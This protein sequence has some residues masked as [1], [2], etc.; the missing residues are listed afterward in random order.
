MKKLPSE[1][2]NPLVENQASITPL[3]VLD[4]EECYAA[5]Q[6]H[7]ARFDGVFFVA[8]STT[9]IYCRPICRV[10]IPKI[11]RCTFY[12][13]AASAEQ[14][15]YRPCLR[16]R[17]ELAP[18]NAQMDAV[19]R[20]AQLA[21]LRIK[22]GALSDI[23]VEGLAEEFGISDRQL[24]RAIDIEYG[25]SPINLAQTY[26]LL[27]AK[28]LLTDT[29]LNMT[30]IA[31]ASGF[32]SV[33]RFN[34][35]FKTKY[36]LNPSEL[37]KTNNRKKLAKKQS[38]KNQ[39]I[40]NTSQANEEGI[41]LRLGYRPP[42]AWHTLIH[43]LCS[44]GHS[45]V[46]C[47]KKN[48]HGEVVYCKTV[49]ISVPQDN[50]KI[51]TLTTTGWISASQDEK[52]HQIIVRISNSLSPHLV[53]LQ[54][55]LR[56]LFDLDAN[57]AV[58]ENHL[59]RDKTLKKIIKETPGIRI[60]GTLDGFELALRAVLGQ[61]ISV[62][63]ATTVFGRFVD[64]FGDDVETPIEGL[65]KTSPNPIT[66]AQA[67]LEEIIGLGLTQRR[68]ATVKELALATVNGKIPWDKN[69]HDLILKELLAL[70][71]IGPWTTQY[72]AMRAL[73]EPNAFPESDLGLMR[74]LNA[75][76]PIDVLAR[77]KKWAP[78]R[79]YGAMYCWTGLSTTV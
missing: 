27:L 17:P 19:K 49:S 60:A 61:Q 73:R 39:P 15:G 64:K 31:F 22:S 47:I 79:A 56:E 43:F 14:A 8:V 45:R 54:I 11:D 16:C 12:H 62:K 51:K 23:G 3:A 69:D 32:S 10:R 6:A 78:W 7:D 50:G 55:K 66:I 42:L 2:I 52:K 28:Q 53:A 9:K 67:S 58:I 20:V 48:K 40:T 1:P 34:D 70:P 41:L 75:E 29:Q 68:A 74:S 77:A 35:A 26:R 65:D 37:R 30:D 72:V 13:H 44:R 25:V 71:G 36:R 76:K 38:A 57:P 59:S 63:A 33:R 21:A 24:R 46:D 4:S 18:G 5:M